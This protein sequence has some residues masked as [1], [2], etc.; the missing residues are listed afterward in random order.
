MKGRGSI[1]GK[2][3]RAPLF[4]LSHAASL[5]HSLSDLL[6]TPSSL[7]PALRAAVGAF[8]MRGAGCTVNDMWDK[9]FDGRVARTASRPLAS[10]RV[11]RTKAFA[12]LAAQGSAAFAV[13]TQFSLD[14]VVAGAAVVPLVIAYPAL[15][16]FTHWPQAALGLAMNYGIVMGPPAV[17][18]TSGFA[19]AIGLTAA[20][21]AAPPAVTAAIST[22]LP[23][24]GDALATAEASTSVALSPAA[25]LGPMF[26]GDGALVST[27]LPLYAGAALWTI[28]YDTIYAHQDKG[29]D[30]K[31]GLKS[32][33]ILMGGRSKTVLTAF[34]L[35]SGGCWAA[36]G[37][38]GDLGAPFLAAAALATGH[39]VWQARTAAYDGSDM[40]GLAKRFIS[41]KWV[42]W[43][44]FFGIVAGKLLQKKT[45]KEEEEEGG[46]RPASLTAAAPAA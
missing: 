13:L 27:V 4:F 25:A 43:L 7:S 10:G 14:T 23:R 36:A 35:A 34:A 22:V 38:G 26:G 1:G 19:K 8:A 15:K 2:R 32:T 24:V 39:Q 12:W 41:N 18:G 44:I 45:E 37:I 30:V 9:D 46:P 33:A 40:Q 17:A 28:V 31:L 3:K 42:G 6:L 16:R 20:L 11:S 5:S 29:D 21:A